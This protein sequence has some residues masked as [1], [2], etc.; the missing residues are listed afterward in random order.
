MARNKFVSCQKI[1][2]WWS[3]IFGLVG[4]KFR[5]KRK[6]ITYGIVKVHL[7]LSVLSPY[8]YR[9]LS[10]VLS[11]IPRGK[12]ISMDIDTASRRILVKNV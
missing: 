5:F 4:N 11:W 12:P 7:P 3:K 1:K 6:E 10:H 2:I 9:N 8:K